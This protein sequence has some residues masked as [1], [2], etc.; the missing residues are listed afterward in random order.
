M[1][2]RGSG[3]I[4]IGGVERLDRHQRYLRAGGRGRDVALV[5]GP[6]EAPGH[7]DSCR[8]AW[9]QG[10]AAGG[11]W[12]GCGWSGS[13]CRRFQAVWLLRPEDPQAVMFG[14]VLVV[15]EVQRCER[16]LV[17][18]AASRDPHV[19]DRAW[20]PASAGCCGQDPPDG[21][22]C[23]IARQDRDARQPAGRFSTAVGA[24]VAD[25]DPLGQLTERYEGDQRF[26]A[27]QARGQRPV[28]LRRCSNEAT[29][30]SRM[31]GCMAT[32]RRGRG[33]ASPA[34]TR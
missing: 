1:F 8:F 30:V 9:L 32:V 21:G 28:S 7:S 23:L 12:E 6:L 15:L 2:R 17:G 11:V 27:D 26:A 22:N 4:G 25:L 19:V 13:G 18:E 29:S 10:S 5:P 34:Q 31:T 24:P 20:P 14:E 16:R 3:T 33:G